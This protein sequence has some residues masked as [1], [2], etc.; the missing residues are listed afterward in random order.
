MHIIYNI[1]RHAVSNIMCVSLTKIKYHKYK[2]DFL[3]TN[4]ILDIFFRFEY[5]LLLKN[6][7]IIQINTRIA[8]Y[9]NYT[10]LCASLYSLPAIYLYKSKRVKTFRIGLGLTFF[11]FSCSMWLSGLPVSTTLGVMNGTVNYFFIR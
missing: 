5:K 2:A 3:M 4:Y 11:F 9:I 1:I 6:K 10:M 8:R 7:L